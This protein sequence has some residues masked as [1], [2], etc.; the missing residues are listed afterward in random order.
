MIEITPKAH[1][2]LKG[3][4]ARNPGHV[5]RICFDGLGCSGP[6]LKL[7]LAP[8]SEDEAVVDVDGIAVVL[9][10]DVTIFSDDQTI[11]YLKS[12][13]GEGFSITSRG[14]FSCGGDCSSCGA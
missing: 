1:E 10:E 13:E 4:L 3:Y 5:V 8:V 6:V 2:I 14:G 11:D 7:T 9:E 12:D